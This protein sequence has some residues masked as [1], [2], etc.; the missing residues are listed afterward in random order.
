MEPLFN[1]DGLTKPGPA[2]INTPLDTKGNTYLH[3]L[4]LRNAPPAL[5]RE[6]VQKLGA[7]VN[8]RN[9]NGFPPL[10]NAILKATPATVACLIELGAEI[11][12]PGSKDI[13]FNATH[14]AAVTGR[15]EVLDVVLKNGG[16]KYVNEGGADEYGINS[17][18]PPLHAAIKKYHYKL[19]E[20]LIK[21][22][23]WPD[24]EAGYDKLTALHLA[25]SNEAAGPMAQ[26]IR[27]GADI[28]HKS[29]DSKGQ[30]PLQY[31]AQLDRPQAAE[32]L[33]RKGADIHAEDKQGMTALMLAASQGHSRVIEKILAF[34]KD[35][36]RRRN[37][38]DHETALMKA[39][40]KGN[41]ATVEM[42]LKAGANPLLADDFNRTAAKYAEDSPN[43]S[44]SN[45]EYHGGYSHNTGNNNQ[46]TRT[47][48]KDAEDKAAQ[49]FFEKKY[50]GRR[51]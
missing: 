46:R 11:Y 21:A 24:A 15:E 22:G 13:I 28:N 38:A 36:D 40:H 5:I 45:W 43:T 32:L 44:N 39:A 49:K 37:G 3:E 34:D 26:L 31:A 30:T 20:P 33:L 12:Y 23:A 16:G 4:C 47:I 10:G 14:L 51:P 17:T 7:D 18:L 48:L 8:A 25:A 2:F 1:S 19:I 50:K 35:V 41:T 29:G 6:A 42:L 9:N 27:L